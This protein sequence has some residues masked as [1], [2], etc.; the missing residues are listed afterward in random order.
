[1]N[2][3]LCLSSSISPCEDL[4]GANVR[5]VRNLLDLPEINLTT[6]TATATAIPIYPRRLD[7]Q[8]LILQFCRVS[9]PC[10]SHR[11]CQAVGCGSSALPPAQVI[12]FK[13]LKRAEDARRLSLL[14]SMLFPKPSHLTR[15]LTGWSLDY[16][17]HSQSSNVGEAE[18]IWSLSECVSANAPLVG[19][20][21]GRSWPGTFALGLP[22]PPP[23]R[24]KRISSSRPSPAL[25][26]WGHHASALEWGFLPLN[27]RRAGQSTSMVSQMSLATLP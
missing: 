27:G 20:C 21:Q 12:L 2:S 4:A 8:S 9:A 17:S 15:W 22:F 23:N 26:N 5:D 7:V 14:E 19:E 10:P 25:G 16:V 24:Q 6:A 1:M 18:E 3:R 13:N 11:Q